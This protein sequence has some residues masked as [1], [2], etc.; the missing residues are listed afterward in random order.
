[1]KT[2]IEIIKAAYKKVLKEDRQTSVITLEASALES[3]INT[4]MKLE[5]CK[6]TREGKLTKLDFN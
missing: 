2:R 4:V 6:P 3:M 1:M 5:Y